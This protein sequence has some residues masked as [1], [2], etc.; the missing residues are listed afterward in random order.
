VRGWAAGHVGKGP[1]FQPLCRDHGLPLGVGPGAEWSVEW[2]LAVQ[3][4]YDPERKT[5][6]MV[7]GG[8]L[9]GGRRADLRR[10]KPPMQLPTA[11]LRPTRRLWQSASGQKDKI[12]GWASL[13]GGHRPR[14]PAEPPWT[15]RHPLA[16]EPTTFRL[17]FQT[18]GATYGADFPK[19]F[20]PGRHSPQT[21][22]RAP[23]DCRHSI[24]QGL[25]N[26]K[27]HPD[28]ASHSTHPCPRSYRSAFV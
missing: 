18:P 1:S 7:G 5:A 19:I 25:L 6:K 12:L 3:V 27:P 26:R 28:R 17:R 11:L 20:E 22:A 8:E 14:G 24:R 23:S 15:R 9:A 10:G 13:R 16:V 4:P 2:P 21:L